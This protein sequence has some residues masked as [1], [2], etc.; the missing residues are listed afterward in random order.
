MLF[1]LK[2][3]KLHYAHTHTH[4]H[5]I[6]Q[7]LKNINVYIYIHLCKNTMCRCLFNVNTH[8]IKNEKRAPVSKLAHD[9]LDIHFLIQLT[10]IKI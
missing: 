5:K 3:Y 4:T 8:S 9:R 7:Y 2:Y 6:I 1:Y 10:S